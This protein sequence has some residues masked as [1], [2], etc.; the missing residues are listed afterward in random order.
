M[1]LVKPELH[2]N[3]FTNRPHV[4][5]RIQRSKITRQIVTSPVG[6]LQQQTFSLIIFPPKSLVI[7]RFSLRKSSSPGPLGG[8]AAQVSVSQVMISGLL[9]RAPCGAL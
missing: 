1:Y 3:R 6:V 8:S 4:Y 9:D 7:E 2:A 5:R